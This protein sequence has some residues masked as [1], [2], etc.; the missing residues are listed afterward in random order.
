N[1][2]PVGSSARWPFG[3]KKSPIISA[4]RPHRRFA[5]ALEK[6]QPADVNDVSGRWELRSADGGATTLVVYH[7]KF[8]AG[9]YIPGFLRRRMNESLLG[10]FRGFMQRQTLTAAAGA[11]K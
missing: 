8:D 11:G 9:L 1:A 3:E 7:G 10:D 2:S 5:S 4:H 6:T